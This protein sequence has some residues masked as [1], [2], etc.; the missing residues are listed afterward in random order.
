MKSNVCFECCFN[1]KNHVILINNNKKTKEGLNITILK[2]LIVI[3]SVIQEIFD[4]LGLLEF[5]TVYY[6]KMERIITFLLT[7]IYYLK[8]FP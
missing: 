6:Y 7:I 5:E 1:H 2:T 8:V 4:S 3:M